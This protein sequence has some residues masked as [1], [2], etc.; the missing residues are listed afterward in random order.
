MKKFP[1]KWYIPA[2]EADQDIVDWVNKNTNNAYVISSSSDKYFANDK[3]YAWCAKHAIPKEHVQ[4]TNQQWHNHYDKPSFPADEKWYMLDS[5]VDQNVVKYIN[6]KYN[7]VLSKCDDKDFAWINRDGFN[8]ENIKDVPSDYTKIT[9]DQFHEYYG[10]TPLKLSYKD[11]IPDEYYY[12]K[13]SSNILIELIYKHI[14]GQRN[15]YLSITNKDFFT[16]VDSCSTDDIIERRWATVDEKEWLNR[17]IIADKYVDKQAKTCY[18]IRKNSKNYKIIN[19]WA[20]K[21]LEKGFF[22]YS[23]S[24]LFIMDGKPFIDS[25]LSCTEITFDEFKAMFLPSLLTETNFYKIER[26]REN[27]DIINE[28]AEINNEDQNFNNSNGL[29]FIKDGKPSTVN[30]YEHETYTE[31]TFDEFERLF[32]TPTSQKIT[33]DMFR[34]AYNSLTT[35]ICDKAQT[36]L[37]SSPKKK[38][39]TIIVEQPNIILLTIKNKK[40]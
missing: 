1:D 6:G 34:E 18:K 7:K 40:K 23:F 30:Y 8:F 3:K 21:G 36:T 15:T 25:T 19:E 35:N 37:V 12:M 27:H 13:F 5:E 2:N 28:W 20:N 29:I 11:S 33:D 24:P 22:D 38:I 39:S 14:K 4:I 31:I 10:N 32:L 9:L 16:N 26:N 17:C